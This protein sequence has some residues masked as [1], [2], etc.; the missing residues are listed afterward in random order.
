MPVYEYYCRTCETTFDKLR[1]MG[2]SEQPADCPHGHTGATRTIT[3]F[4]TLGKAGDEPV[5]FA[6]GGGCCGGGGCAC[7]A[8]RN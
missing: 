3:V 1:P 2:Q 6:G 7:S 4:A 5:T 8:G